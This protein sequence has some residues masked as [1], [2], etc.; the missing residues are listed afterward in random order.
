MDW[1]CNWQVEMSFCAYAEP[2]ANPD[3]K[4]N[5]EP[6][7]GSDAK[8]DARTNPCLSSGPVPRKQR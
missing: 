2:D 6:D 5:T 1:R 7:S 3:A 8:P 4:P